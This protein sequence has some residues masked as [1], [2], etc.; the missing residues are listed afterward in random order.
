MVVGGQYD[1]G[2]GLSDSSFSLLQILYQFWVLF[3]LVIVKQYVSF[4][5]P[6]YFH[7]FQSFSLKSY[8]ASYFY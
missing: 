3:I 7:V 6:Q 4:N 2:G 1:G 8:L 5:N